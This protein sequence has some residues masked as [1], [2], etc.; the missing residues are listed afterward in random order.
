MILWEGGGKGA[1]THG[2]DDTN[3]VNQNVIWT[4]VAN[5]TILVW[6]RWHYRVKWGKNLSFLSFVVEIKRIPQRRTL[7]KL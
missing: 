2:V 1:T 5:D 6:Q 7:C 4:L 3:I